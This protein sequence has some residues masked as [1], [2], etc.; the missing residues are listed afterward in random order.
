[1]RIL[2]SVLALVAILWIGTIGYVA[3]EGWPVA[4]GFFM[5]LITLS[6]VGYGETNQLS[7]SG[8]IFTSVLILICLVAMT[9][10][11]ALLTSFILEQ[12][13]SGKYFR[14][15]MLK[16]I[17]KLKDHV[18]ICGTDSMAFPLIERLVRKRIPVVLV[19]DDTEAA[20]VLKK[21]FRRLHVVEGNPTNELALANANVLAA[22]TVVAATKS[23]VDNLL[24]GITCKDIGPHVAVFAHSNDPILGN[25]MR[26]SGID[27]VIS[28]A[29]LCGAHVATLIS[30][31]S[32]A[33]V[34]P[35]APS[36][37]QPA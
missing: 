29:Q 12:E 27:E 18:V 9:Y 24:V 14:R 33:P 23:E 25:R 31:M 7:A 19:T 1:M 4:D 6:T 16:L 11:S 3:I 22:K 32:S 13:L 5:T 36:V 30:D 28:P 15:R 20:E 21:R 8:R 35:V 37:T 34:A 10:W 26:K 17:S 2:Y